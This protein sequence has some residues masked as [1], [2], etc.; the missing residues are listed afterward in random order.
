MTA[1]NEEQTEYLLVVQAPCYRVDEHTFATESAFAEH[2]KVLQRKLASRFERIWIA[3]PEHSPEFYRANRGHLGHIVEQ[4]ERIFY[5][6]LHRVDAST[7]EFWTRQAVP[8][9][10]ALRRMT[11]RSS[12]VHS[13]LASDIFRPS[14]FLANV[15]GTLDRCKTLFIVD[16]DFRKD[17]WRFWKTG[18]WSLKSYLL[19]R[20]L[21][22]PIR[23]AQVLIATRT[24]SLLLLKS[25][26]MVRDFGR[27]RPNVRNFW[28][29]AHSLAQVIDESSLERHVRRLN[30]LDRP[31]ALIYF[32]RFVSSKGLDLMI[33]A[34]SQARSRSGR[35]F[36]L[37]LVGTG[38]E[39]QRLKALVDELGAKDWVRFNDPV[40][41]GPQLFS[42]ISKADLLLATPISED[43]PRS[44]F[45][46]MA[47]GLSILGFDI[48]YYVSLSQE[49]EA[50]VTSPWPDIDALS[51]R[52]VSL[53]EDRPRLA[54][55]CRAAVAFA[56]ANTQ[57]TWID[58]RVE[59]TLSLIDR[60]A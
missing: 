50:V 27:G 47:A 17:A 1:Q 34:V 15:A 37:D 4:Q 19:C 23:V 40:P 2:L 41:Y 22:D 43:T 30:D 46:A 26:S 20:A 13:G 57:E 12:I 44:A 16:I 39:L 24:S 10:R 6:P 28:D 49:T 55:M 56:K 18:Q 7:W 48:D 38:V 9:W 53:D 51:E 58:R 32:G 31:I 45:D 60:H 21:Y 42:K 36:T 52:L 59:W 35:A 25:A 33:R 5:V 29:T 14:L 3:A 11:R 8:V 54:R